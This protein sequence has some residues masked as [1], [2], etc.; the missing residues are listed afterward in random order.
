MK[1]DKTNDLD[2]SMQDLVA[3]R[4]NTPENAQLTDVALKNADQSTEQI[5]LDVNGE[6]K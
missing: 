6:C 4:T 2:V 1:D 3:I 5:E